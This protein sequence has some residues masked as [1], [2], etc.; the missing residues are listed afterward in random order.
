MPEFGLVRRLRRAQGGVGRGVHAVR[1]RRERFAGQCLGEVRGCEVV[2]RLVGRGEQGVEVRVGAVLG[3]AV[4]PAQAAA[5]GEEGAPGVGGGCAV[6]PL[7]A[8]GGLGAVLR[9]EGGVAGEVWETVRGQRGSSAVAGV[10]SCVRHVRVGR[11]TC[12][13]CA[14]T[15]PVAVGWASSHCSVFTRMGEFLGI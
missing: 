12:E 3:D 7:Q 8:R 11:G 2:R 13:K 9:R 5:A 15:L 6:E 14:A 4:G 1:E 10:A